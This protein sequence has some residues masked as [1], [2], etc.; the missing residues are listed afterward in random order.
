MKSMSKSERRFF[1]LQARGDESKNYLKLF[2]AIDKLDEYDEEK[3]VKKL[4]GEKLLAHL[5]SEK[6]YLYETILRALRSYHKDESPEAQARSLLSDSE[7][8]FRRGLYSSCE[9]RI[10]LCLRLCEKHELLAV[11]MN[12]L[13]LQRRLLGMTIG[14]HDYET[15][16]AEVLEKKQ[17]VALKLQEIVDYQHVEHT[18]FSAKFKLGRARTEDFD[19]DEFFRLPLID[20]DD[21]PKSK[22]ARMIFHS[23]IGTFADLAGLYEKSYNSRRSLVEVIEKEY[24]I[25]SAINSYVNALSNFVFVAINLHRYNEALDALEKLRAI[26][27]LYPEACTGVVKARILIRIYIY[28]LQISFENGLFAW[29]Q[30]A[31]EKIQ[32]DLPLLEEKKETVRLLQLYLFLAIYYI[33]NEKP[34]LALPWLNKI[35]NNVVAG[36]TREGYCLTYILNLVV[37]YELDNFLILDS[38]VKSTY[39]FLAKSEWLYK[40]EATIL[41]FLG[42]TIS[43]NFDKAD[44]QSIFR[45]FH[46]KISELSKNPNEAKFLEGFD[47]LAWTQSK[48]SKCSLQEVIRAKA[49]AFGVDESRVEKL[50]VEEN[51]RL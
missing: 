36:V 46:D 28:A 32:R 11:Q 30:A 19:P 47:L 15:R 27:A 49:A 22:Y 43:R 34:N 26:P 12:A 9:K 35:L 45:E 51:F 41:K 10:Q 7:I 29:Q 40:T 44:L 1:T 8:L 24:D 39:R 4:S 23:S 21:L 37:H 13:E 20:R 38:L 33:Y 6:Q 42:R 48:I 16:D 3:L 50:L 14:T 31:V 25:P 2:H 5:H 17:E 18:V